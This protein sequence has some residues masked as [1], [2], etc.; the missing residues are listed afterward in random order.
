MNVINLAAKFEL[1]N[2]YW[3][4]KIV[5]ALNGQQVK[6]VKLKGEF[7]WHQHENEDEL[8]LVI[9][10]QLLMRLRDQDLVLNA[11][12]LCIVPRRVE[13]KPVAEEEVHVLL[14]EP[15][16]TF[17]TGNVRSEHSRDQLEWI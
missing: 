11:G 12:E 10:G 14:F 3:S 6:L 17:N 2:D 16:S 1:F 9:K 8:F 13:H 5:G 7:V 15:T 4:P